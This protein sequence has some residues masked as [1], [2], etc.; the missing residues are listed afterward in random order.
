L[1]ELE[2]LYQVAQK[3]NV[4]GSVPSVDLGHLYHADTFLNALRQ[5]TA[6]KLNDSMDNLLLV[7]TFDRGFDPGHDVTVAITG[8]QVQVSHLHRWYHRCIYNLNLPMTK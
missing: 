3:G 1:V 8:L 6:R 7:T 5:Q 4:I 2:K